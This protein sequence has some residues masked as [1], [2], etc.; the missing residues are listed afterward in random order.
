M[1]YVW[2]DGAFRHPKTNEPMPQ[3]ERDGICMPTV[4]SDI[5]PYQSII[6]GTVVGSRSSQRYDLEKNNCVLAPPFSKRMQP[7]E[8]VEHKARQAKV[9]EARRAVK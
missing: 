9:L 3:P 2:R 7:E 6:D 5:E 1:R 4:R 8:Y